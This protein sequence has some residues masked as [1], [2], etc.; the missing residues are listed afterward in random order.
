MSDESYKFVSVKYLKQ[1]IVIE[2]ETP[3]PPG[4]PEA[5][6]KRQA[7]VLFCYTATSP[8]GIIIHSQFW[9][10][11]GN[12]NSYLNIYICQLNQGKY[13]STKISEEV[14]SGYHSWAQSKQHW[15]DSI[16]I[17]DKIV[18]HKLPLNITEC[19]KITHILFLTPTAQ[20]SHSSGHVYTAKK[21]KKNP[22]PK[23]A[24]LRSQAY[25]LELAGLCY[26]IKNSSADI[27]HSDSEIW[28]RRVGLRARAPAQAGM[29]TLLFLVP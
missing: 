10:S 8:L 12:L 19:S 24:S 13:Y 22:K 25:R 11:G 14:I 16:T 29:S 7:K 4:N 5:Q 20:V 2:L 3:C 26:C 18:A 17:Q 6:T 21:N 9:R 1:R 28:Q 23:A 27:A 15:N